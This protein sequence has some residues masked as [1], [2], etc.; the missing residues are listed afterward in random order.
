MSENIRDWLVAQGLA[1]YADAFLE[2]KIDFQILPE[3]TNEDLREI[4][5]VA[6]GDRR[7]LL[8]SIADI[9]L[10][11]LND[12]QEHENKLEA[13]KRQVTVMFTDI[14]GF[15]SLS[16][17]L[18]AEDTHALLNRFFAVTDGIVEKYGGRIDKH[19]G[20]AVMA[21]FGAPIS[22]S[23]DSERAAR[24]ALDIHKAMASFDPPLSCHI[25]IASGQ[26]IA[27][28]TGSQTH[29]E[30]TITGDGVNLAS[31]L[32]E[33][34]SAGDTVVS[35]HIQRALGPLFVGETLG[36]QDIKGFATPI[37]VFLLSRM[38]RDMRTRRHRF[39]GRHR[40]LSLFTSALERCKNHA[41][42]E[43]HVLLGEP[44]IGKTHL[45]EEIAELAAS[46]GF[47]IHDGAVMDFG[48]LEGQSAVQAV[49]ASLLDL[50]STA[51]Q[52]TRL[53][54][55]QNAVDLGWISSANDTHLRALLDVDQE[56]GPAEVYAALDN[57]A[58]R[59]A[60]RNVI[61]ELMR[62]RCSQS[63][64]LIRIEDAHWAQSDVMTAF[65]HIGSATANLPII[66]LM[67]S[68]VAGDPFSQE[69]QSQTDGAFLTKLELTALNDD[70]ARELIAEFDRID[71]ELLEACVQ[72]AGGNPLF[73]EQL[74]RNIDALRDEEIPGSI[75]GL[76][77]S[78]LD[79]LDAASRAAIQAASVLGP[80]F[81]PDAL[82]YLL[83]DQKLE[84]GVLV[85]SALIREDGNALQ[86][87]HALI[88]DGSYETLIKSDR[89]RLHLRAADWYEGRDASL[90]ARHLERAG[91]PEAAAAYLQA[92]ENLIQA[93]QYDE[94]E[95]LIARALDL[96]TSAENRFDL[97]CV[98][99]ELMRLRG[100]SSEAI[101]A[102]QDAA[103][104]AISALQ[105]YRVHIGLAQAARQ[106]SQY[107]IALE[108][109]DQAEQAA[110]QSNSDHDLAQI[111]YVRGNI[112]FPLGRTQEALQSNETAL[113]LARS[114]G[115]VRLE[116]G[117]LSGFGDANFMQGTMKSAAEY[118]TQAVDRA[119]ENGLVRDLAANLHN[120][121]VSRC[122]SGD[123]IQGKVDAEEAIQV[124]QKY[125]AHVPECVAQTCMGI[126][127]SFF[128]EF[129]LALASFARSCEIAE[130]IGASRLEAQGLEHLSRAQT[131]AGLREDAIKTGR[132]AVEIAL[133]HGRNF[134][135]AKALSALALA[136]DDADE[137]DR[138]LVQAR[139]IIAEG[140]V[141]HSQLHYYADASAL[142]LR[143]RDWA[144]AEEF[145]GELEEFTRKEPLGMATLSIRETRLIAQSASDNIDH[146]AHP[147]FDALSSAFGVMGVRYTLNGP[148][149]L[150]LSDG[151]Q[152]KTS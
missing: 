117:A 121:S 80:R 59:R 143:R 65:A 150:T 16:S 30:Y 75:Q 67:T 53:N 72:R 51:D 82:Q 8:R 95:T 115:S 152:E 97:L 71:P 11:E 79:A 52:P 54:A 149:T 42:G 87:A 109:L 124:S 49:I 105:K 38:A 69:W 46:L 91:S 60:R 120:L 93:Y 100:L 44:G 112:Y 86:F 70:H 10:P 36:A 43:I 132:S 7:R 18:D 144:Q 83:A 17:N 127:S 123:V 56:A 147:D 134:V 119:R 106:A 148:T 31:R 137:Q 111:N 146:T 48:A 125:F 35:D 77:Q 128:G 90:R 98:G 64:V 26:V 61:G 68:R 76:V 114:V 92:C 58:R 27:S 13:A 19:I 78:R 73:L 133:A 12:D 45:S 34:A 136:L 23:N 88:R 135:G 113:S 21:V 57:N 4:G 55:I 74:L 32:T 20:D 104:L 140:S 85:R 22:H 122:Y 50:D 24:A 110:Q 99:S 151:W 37:E 141:G 6:V 84:T 89:V 25:G 3:L 145:A 33:L 96:K 139:E 118:Y 1:D 81:A 28:D 102:F 116:V 131:W 47:R 94:A 29:S 62:A 66:L 138:L 103:E 39:I 14:S 9:S 15:T 40:E 107:S 41:K 101:N 130:R 63:P 129:D 126:A 108:S 5:V 2:N 142:M